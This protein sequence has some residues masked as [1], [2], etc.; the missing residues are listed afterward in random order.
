[1]EKEA[2]ACGLGHSIRRPCK[3]PFGFENGVLLLISDRLRVT[4]RP[5]ILTLDDFIPLRFPGDP[6]R[7]FGDPF[8]FS[9]YDQDAWR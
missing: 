9:L 7:V 2:A 1:M 5:R 6:L 3:I 8:R 4:C